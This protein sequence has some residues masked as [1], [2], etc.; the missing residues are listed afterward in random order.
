MTGTLGTFGHGFT[1]AGH[2][3]STAIA[4]A[5]LE[6]YQADDIVGHVGAVAG[7]FAD[8]LRELALHPLV[9]HARAIGLLGAIELMAD[10]RQKIPF[11][12]ARKVGARLVELVLERGV[13]LRPPG[14]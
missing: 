6:A 8:R 9:G 11:D 10:G 2:P 3:L 13:I 5:A 12:P 14:S 1:F 4:R 7:R